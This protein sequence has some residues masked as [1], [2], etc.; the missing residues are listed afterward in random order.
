MTKPLFALFSVLFWNKIKD[1]HCN[2]EF[3]P[4]VRPVNIKHPIYI[5]GLFFCKIPP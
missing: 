5:F 2:I 3:T 4:D 1:I